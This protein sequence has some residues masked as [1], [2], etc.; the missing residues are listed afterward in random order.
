MLSKKV[1]MQLD[2]LVAKLKTL[3]LLHFR[4]Y[5]SKSKRNLVKRKPQEKDNFHKRT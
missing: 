1:K 5:S 4:S 2:K 3:H